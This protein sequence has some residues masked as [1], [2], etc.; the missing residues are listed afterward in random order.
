[1]K[2]RCAGLLKSSG[3]TTMFIQ[4]LNDKRHAVRVNYVADATVV[5]KPDASPLQGRLKNL[6]IDGILLATEQVAAA[7]TLCTV[8]IVVQ[9]RHSRLLIDDLAGEVVRSDPGELGIKFLHP[10]EWL[11][12]FHVYQSKSAPV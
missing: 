5:F 4:D 10:F 3:G 1:M 8:T 6:S 7:G 12:L 2:K 11:A 9:D